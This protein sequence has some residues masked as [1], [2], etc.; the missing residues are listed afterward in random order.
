[1]AGAITMSSVIEDFETQPSKKRRK[2]SDAAGVKTI[3]NYFSPVAKVAEKPFSPPRSNNIADYFKKT[4]PVSKVTSPQ[5]QPKENTVPPP[6]TAPASAATSDPTVSKRAKA[7]SKKPGKKAGRSVK[8]SLALNPTGTGDE[9]VGGVESKVQ[10]QSQPAD[11]AVPAEGTESTVATVDNKCKTVG[12]EQKADKNNPMDNV[13]PNAKKAAALVES[14]EN[15]TLSA[16]MD[17]EMLDGVVPLGTVTPEEKGKKAKAVKKAGR[18]GKTNQVQKDVTGMQEGSE[19][20]Q[21]QPEP[22]SDAVPEMEESEETQLN[23]STVTVSFSDFLKNHS[24]K[25]AERQQRQDGQE[26]MESTD[27]A[28]SRLSPQA[29]DQ[30]TDRLSVAKLSEDQPPTQV[31]PRTLTVLAEIHPISPD[32]DI[33]K[34][35]G[36]KV[37]SIFTTCRKTKDKPV[38]PPQPQ[39]SS[40]QPPPPLQ[41]PPRKSN[42][43]LQEEDLELAVLES[44]APKCSQAERKQFMNAFKQA[45]VDAAKGKPAKAGKQKQQPA[46]SAAPTDGEKEEGEKKE[47]ENEKTGVKANAKS[48]RK[49]G[50]AGEEDDDDTKAAEGPKGATQQVAG[51]KAKSKRKK[52]GGGGGAG[53]EEDGD[54]T[55]AAIG[56]KGAT[57]QVAGGKAKSKR[58]KAFAEAEEETDSKA[59]VE[60]KVATQQVAAKRK[61]GRAKKDQKENVPE[62]PTTAVATPAESTA[63]VVPPAES[64]APAVVKEEGEDNQPSGDQTTASETRRRSTRECSKKQSPPASQLTVISESEFNNAVNSSEAQ[65]PSG[66]PCTPRTRYSKRGVFK[67]HMLA[68]PDDKGSPIRMKFTRVFTSPGETSEFEILSPLAKEGVKKRKKAQKLVQKAKARQQSKRAVAT[69]EKAATSPPPRRS[70]RC[71]D[72]AK[73]NYCEPEDSVICLDED[74]STSPNKAEEPKTKTKKQVRSLNDVL[75]KNAPSTKVA[76]TAAAGPGNKVAPVFLGKKPQRQSITSIFDESSHD[77]SDA[78]QDDE[79]F[80][81]RREFLKSGLPESFKK[82]IAKTAAT[83]EAYTLSCTSFQGV[84]H[85]LQRPEECPLWSLPW[86]ECPQLSCLKEAMVA[87]VSSPPQPV[88]GKLSLS[89]MPARRSCR[90]QVV[91]GWREELSEEVQRW[92]LE[93]ITAANPSFPSQRL[94]TQLLKRRAEHLLKP[95]ATEG[96]SVSKATG[97]VKD[98]QPLVGKRKRE[99]DE[100]QDAATEK[101][102]KRQRASRKET[103]TT[104]STS[105]GEAPGPPRRGRGGRGRAARRQQQEEEVEAPAAEETKPAVASTPAAPQKAN[106]AVV[107]SL[108]SSEHTSTEDVAREDVMW[109]EKYQPQHSSDVVGNMLSVRRLHSWLREW[110][111]RADHEERKKQQERKSVE[112]CNES[113]MSECGEGVEED[114]LCNTLLITGPTG[115]G[116]TAAVYACAQE[117]GFK[118]FEVNC[119]SQRSGRQILSQLK[120]ATQSHQVDI[121]GANALK[122]TFFSNFSGSAGGSGGSGTRPGSSP[123]KVNSPRRVVSS[124]HKPPQSPRRGPTKRGSL[125]PTSLAN[126]FKMGSKPT[127]T[128]DTGADAKPL[129]P[130]CKSPR[131]RAKSKA[132]DLSSPP[133]VAPSTIT[134]PATVTPPVTSAP[135]PAPAPA[136]SKAQGEEQGKRTATSLILFEE[137][138]VIFDDD[139]G[140]LAA[141]KTFMSTTKRPVILTTS[142]PM[143]RTSFDGYLEEIH[144]DTPSVTDL[145]SYL[146]LLCVAESVRVGAE[147][148]ASLLRC[149]GGDV[150]QS[151]LQLQLWIRSGASGP[152]A[153]LPTLT[154]TQAVQESESVATAEQNG[155][156]DLPPCESN[157]TSSLLGLLNI[158]QQ[159][160]LPDFL[161]GE[162]AN[163]I[164]WDL[165]VEAGRTGHNLLYSNME[166]LLPL[167]TRLLALSLSIPS[168]HKT[169]PDQAAPD[170]AP[171]S[172]IAPLPLQPGTPIPNTKPSHLVDTEDEASPLKVSSRMRQKKHTHAENR[173]PFQSDSDS[174]DGFLSLARPT[175][176]SAHT[177]VEP[178]PVVKPPVVRRRVKLTE[179]E[180]KAGVPVSSALGAM[181][182]F[183][184]HMS[185]LDASLLCPA[186]QVTIEGGCSTP[187]AEYGWAPTEIRSGLTDEARVECG[188]GG[189]AGRH[190]AMEEQGR[191][192]RAAVESL[193]F[194]RCRARV[195]LAWGAVQ[196]LQEVEEE[197]VRKMALE[198]ITLP[199]APHRQAFSIM[200]QHALCQPGSVQRRSE[201]MRS[202]CSSRVGSSRPAVAMDLLPALRTICRSEQLKEQGKIKRR[203]LHY[204]DS[205]NLGLPKQTLQLLAS[206]FQ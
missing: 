103:G 140:F 146:R 75:G 14:S 177:S 151:L 188:A 7:Q 145:S 55:K 90:D 113:W 60:P 26:L 63:V 169:E 96:D 121:Q 195:E 157:C 154:G 196:A 115:V 95:T 18:K 61:R 167:P 76:K 197:G 29:L 186:S 41:A 12:K 50:G 136:A 132:D 64:E 77:A 34:A 105:P 179:A 39:A 87:M 45:G 25:G 130:A 102:A 159:G 82:Q 67:S 93:E 88:V 173:G 69:E 74:E 54:D 6:E 174:D 59:V 1:M 85:V 15:Q 141:I 106:G 148:V 137:V 2:D 79:K 127:P 68:P 20:Q 62:E 160:S 100:E 143:F 168:A 3:T 4:P 142:D 23:L 150:R 194:G 78:S 52:G 144:F 193:S 99:E 70:S 11:T 89:I 71:Q 123:R 183:L 120:E 47:E 33:S 185:Y 149:T 58:K 110:K 92:L 65:D 129:Q 81:A 138:D 192:I 32:Q 5:T 125:A 180:R 200:P 118:V 84:V 49:K 156:P 162:S 104:S 184:D 124:P 10:S 98:L 135:A 28:E 97:E 40:E 163:P 21:P 176:T 48:K 171:A 80:R 112:D 83:R 147:D 66:V 139:S 19:Q 36:Q 189:R 175:S 178:P 91:S 111:L 204:L 35:L 122:P 170:P 24:P 44:S 153:G 128:K 126:F 134:P 51:G 161:K 166:A 203:F 206:D 198:E 73:K 172:A 190:W 117:L 152:R 9:E 101:G 16:R 31:S 27:A 133:A 17:S 13:T 109:T 38:T 187:S 53:E 94:L 46:E 107:D 116:K 22:P 56:P 57:Q 205:I 181:A 155:K 43:V 158:Q 72:I 164:C 114:L 182:D 119:S 86:P 199:V 202:V 37:A 42:V 191:E 30:D 131:K 8:K 108:L 165:L 201:L